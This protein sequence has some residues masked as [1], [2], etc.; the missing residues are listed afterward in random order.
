MKKKKQ[1][2]KQREQRV[3]ITRSFS[4]KLNLGNYQTADFFCS[5]KKE[6]NA[7]YAEET[8][9]A[10]EEFCRTQVLQSVARFP[11]QIAE[12]RKK[13][14][15]ASRPKEEPHVFTPVTGIKPRLV[16]EN[17]VERAVYDKVESEK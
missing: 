16:V 6:I 9:R 7:K 4:F 3:E 12:E 14:E 17:G 5:E 15:A 8:S 13:A 11:A 10:L 1:A 2:K